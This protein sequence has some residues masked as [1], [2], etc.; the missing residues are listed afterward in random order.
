M[1][2]GGRNM[3]KFWDDIKGKIAVV[4]LVGLL[5]VLSW[6]ILDKISFTESMVERKADREEVA[7]KADAKDMAYL[8]G[9]LSV[10]Q[11][12][13]DKLTDSVNL[14]TI[15]VERHTAASQGGK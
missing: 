3:T 6:L 7:R 8:G 9:Q 2:E 5:P 12:K 11:A 1:A 10:M 15:T 4:L 14:L 13:L